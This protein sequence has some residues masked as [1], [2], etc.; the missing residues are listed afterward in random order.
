MGQKIHPVGLRVGV[1]RGFDSQWYY[2]KKG[3]GA[4][5]LQDH[6]IRNFIKRRTGLGNISR[7]EIERAANRIKVT[8]F[9]AR[10]GAIIGRG[11][12]GI[13]ELTDTLNRI[14]RRED[15]TM[16]VQV[17]VTEVRQPELDAQLVAENI[18]IQLEKRISHRRAMRQAMTRVV[19]LNG[20]G[21]KVQVSGR[22]G[23]SEIARR[24]GDKVGKIPLHT[25]R[26]DIDYGTAT[27]RT[28]YGSVGVK[29]W[30]YKGEVLPERRLREME[31]ARDEREGGRPERRERRG[32]GRDGG[33]DGG[34]NRDGGAAF[35]STRSQDAAPA[36][37]AGGEA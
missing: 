12:K 15:P 37:S 19:R 7:I 22:L 8:I 21:I 30:I 6:R 32:G 34:R 9:T 29:V 17:N 4:A 1:I 33:R 28:I 2:N 27:A 35:G 31:A 25:I 11:G 23:G 10:P 18:A 5:L 20:R 16:V 13:D 26:A 14:V 36:P 3:Y 24:E